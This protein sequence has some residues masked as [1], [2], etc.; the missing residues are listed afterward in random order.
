MR[1]SG[2]RFALALIS[3][4]AAASLVFIVTGPASDGQFIEALASFENQG[5]ADSTFAIVGRIEVEPTTHSVR[6]DDTLES[7]AREYDLTPPQLLS[8]NP[9]RDPDRPLIPSARLIVI[10]GRPLSAIAVEYNLVFPEDADQGVPLLRDRNPNLDFFNFR[11]QLYAPA[12][13]T[14]TLF[15]S[16][17]IAQLADQQRITPDDILEANPLGSPTNPEGALTADSRLRHGDRIVFPTAKITEAAIRHRLG[18]DR[19]WIARYG[20]FLWGVVRFDYGDA[21]LTP[22][23]ALAAVARALPRTVQLNLYTAAVA[24]C[25]AALFLLPAAL[26]RLNLNLPSRFAQLRP[27]D[28]TAPLLMLALAVPAF[29][30]ALMLFAA[31]GPGGITL[32]GLWTIPITDPGAQDIVNDPAAFFALYSLPALCAAL[33]PAA[34]VVYAVR[35]G[36]PPAQAAL[37]ALRFWLPVALGLNLTLEPLFNIQGLGTLVWLSYAQADLRV[38]AAVAVVTALFI[39]AAWFALDVARDALDPNRSAA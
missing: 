19:S 23:P 15:Y 18:I 28:G 16:V 11:G 9:E 10:P 36:A 25:F 8:L 27:A 22:E 37:S 12:A 13:A 20:D 31:V 29:W 7:I 2:R 32:N 14:L 5:V 34:A 30:L 6:P 26:P 35:S 3:V 1:R 39:A 33:L 24:A 21:F 17:S 4:W 38:L